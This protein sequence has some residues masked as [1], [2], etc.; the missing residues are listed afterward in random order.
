MT[1]ASIT[2]DLD[3]ENN[4]SVLLETD[5]SREVRIV[6]KD[7]HVIEEHSAPYPI[8]LCIFSGGIEFGIGD[9]THKLKEGDII[10]IEANIPFD[11]KAKKDSI[12]RLSLSKKDT[13]ERIEDLI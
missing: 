2:K 13:I 12:I 10:S 3:Y 11:L 4:I 6:L 5:T 1:I 7:G 9:E 8:L